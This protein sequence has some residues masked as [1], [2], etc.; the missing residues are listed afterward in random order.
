MGLINFIDDNP[1]QA[2]LDYIDE[3]LLPRSTFALRQAVRAVR[4]NYIESVRKR[5]A[6]VEEIYIEDLMTGRDPVEG[7]RAFMEKRTPEWKNN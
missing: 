1:E 4:E 5:L 3:H 6:R 7:L 2:A